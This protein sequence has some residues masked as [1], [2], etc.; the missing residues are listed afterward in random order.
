MLAA[1]FWQFFGC[2]GADEQFLSHTVSE[3]KYYIPANGVTQKIANFCA[4]GTIVR[5]LIKKCEKL[6]FFFDVKK[7][8]KKNARI[9]AKNCQ[10][11]IPRSLVFLHHRFAGEEERRVHAAARRR[12]ANA[13]R[14]GNRVFSPD[15]PA[16]DVAA[17]YGHVLFRSICKVFFATCRL[18]EWGVGSTQREKT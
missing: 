14:R 9:L 1:I 2:K 12:R 6:L 16:A 7:K 4:A 18:L 3:Y 10:Y 17:L 8:F 13:H 5:R 15:F 11:F